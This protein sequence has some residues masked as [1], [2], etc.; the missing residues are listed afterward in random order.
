[1]DGSIAFLAPVV[2]LS[3]L[4]GATV[5][6]FS[7]PLLM[8]VLSLVAFASVRSSSGKTSSGLAASAIV[9]TLTA[10]SNSAEMQAGGVALIFWLM[11]RIL[12]SRCRWDATWSIALALLI[13]PIPGFNT[14]V[15][16]CLILALSLIERVGESSWRV[17]HRVGPTLAAGAIVCLVALPLERGKTHTRQ[18]NITA[19]TVKKIVR[20][21]PR[22]TWLV[23]SPVQEVALTYGHGWHLELS[24]FVEKYTVDEVQ[25]P[26]FS[27]RFPVTE[28]FVFVEKQPLASQAMASGLSGL[29]THFDAPMAPYLL[30]LNRASMQ[31]RAARLL[32]AY[33]ATHR[34]TEVYLEDENLI[35]Y[36]IR[37]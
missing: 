17:L 10:I 9:V 37:G 5:I 22:N 8:G 23:V 26:E 1:M 30:R 6:R 12:W 11:S 14:I 18:Y 4:D 21:F 3:S 27:F 35:V 29:G 33:Q 20:E 15:C 24:E 32:A 25:R 31:F 34:N 7:G 19:R 13:E 36:R 2:F 28:T 16:G